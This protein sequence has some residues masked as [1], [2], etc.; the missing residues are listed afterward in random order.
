MLPTRCGLDEDHVSFTL[1]TET[2]EPD[3]YREAIEAD[4]QGKWI[5]AMEQEMDLWIETKYGR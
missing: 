2:G 1:V 4:D 3:S 5:T